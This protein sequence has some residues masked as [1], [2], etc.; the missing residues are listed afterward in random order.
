MH[1]TAQRK[2]STNRTSL[3][4][5]GYD[6]VRQSAE[7]TQVT[8]VVENRG[9]SDAFA[10]HVDNYAIQMKACSALLPVV[11]WY[12]EDNAPLISEVPT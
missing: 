8:V 10:V 4:E 2:E 3:V 5:E 7:G 11:T 12:T 1:Q 6:T 9:T